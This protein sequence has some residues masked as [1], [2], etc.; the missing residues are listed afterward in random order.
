MPATMSAT[1]RITSPNRIDATRWPGR[2]KA[3]TTSEPLA[4]TTTGVDGGSGLCSSELS[5]HWS[6]PTATTDA[7]TAGSSRRI[8]SPDRRPTASSAGHATMPVP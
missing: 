4:S 2:K 1:P 8:R 5:C 3:P 6:H 7:P